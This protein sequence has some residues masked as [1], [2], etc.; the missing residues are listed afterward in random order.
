[1]VNVCTAVPSFVRKAAGNVLGANM[2]IRDVLNGSAVVMAAEQLLQQHWYVFVSCGLLMYM[3]QLMLTV[4]C[5]WFRD[6]VP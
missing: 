1:M 4:C 3:Q 6:C 5:Q 2:D